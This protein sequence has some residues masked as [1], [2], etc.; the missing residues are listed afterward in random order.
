MPDEVAYGRYDR[1]TE[2]YYVGELF[3]H[4]LEDW[5]LA[6]TFPFAGVV[7]AMVESDPSKR[8]PSFAAV[9]AAMSPMELVGHKLS[10]NDLE[11]CKDVLKLITNA[12]LELD[13]S[14]SA[15]IDPASV[16]ERLDSLLASCELEDNLPDVSLLIKCFVSGSFN[17]WPHVKP[18]M[19]LLRSFR[20]AF[21]AM[22]PASQRAV[23]RNV[24]LR[25]NLIPRESDEI[26]F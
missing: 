22:P 21:A 13:A 16:L 23:M 10:D 5:G 4:S 6:E 24:E 7:A 8:L 17:Y 11:V 19:D 26:P 25:L 12:T 1:A 14:A 15:A 2:V 18:N 20:S 3:K 9:R